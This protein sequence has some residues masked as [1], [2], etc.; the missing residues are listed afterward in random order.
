MPYIH[1]SLLFKYFISSFKLLTLAILTCSTAPLATLYTVLFTEHALLFGII[2]PWTPAVSAVL[3]IAPK[4]CGSSIPSSI[5]IKGASFLDF[6][7][8]KISSD[9]INRSYY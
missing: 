1:T 4:L 2:I 6:A 5:N 9:S 3:I 7:S 8:F